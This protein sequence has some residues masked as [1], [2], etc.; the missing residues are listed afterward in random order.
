MADPRQSSEF[1]PKRFTAIAGTNER[2]YLDARQPGVTS[3]HDARQTLNENVRRIDRPAPEAK[4]PK[5]IFAAAP[6]PLPGNP[7]PPA[8]AVIDRWHKYSDFRI[9]V[10][11]QHQATSD[12][13][14]ESDAFHTI[15]DGIAWSKTYHAALALIYTNPIITIEVRG[16]F[17]EQI[18]IDVPYLHFQGIGMPFITFTGGDDPSETVIEVTSGCT[19]LK[20]EGFEIYN[21]NIGDAAILGLQIDEGV[22]SYSDHSDIWFKDCYLH[23]S[24]TQAYI[25][26][27]SY[28]E[29]CRFKSE[30]NLTNQSWAGASVVCR[31][32]TG[33]TTPQ[34]KWTCFSRCTL[35]GETGL[36]PIKKGEAFAI[37]AMF[38]DLTTW[39]TNIYT[40]GTNAGYSGTEPS[41]SLTGVRFEWCRII[42]WAENFGWALE[43]FQSKII[44]GKYINNTGAGNIHLLSHVFTHNEGTHPGDPDVNTFNW[45]D[46]CTARVNYLVNYDDQG[47]VGGGGVAVSNIWL[48][49]L[50]HSA[51]LGPFPGGSV[52]FNIG[53]VAGPPGAVPN[54]HPQ[55]S[56]SSKAFWLN[57]A[58]IPAVMS[59]LNVPYVF[60][61]EGDMEI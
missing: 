50:K 60:N 59:I 6:G 52:V 54:V 11:N 32:A 3:E 18:V 41:R 22:Q 1:N 58:V 51:P 34:S 21:P 7:F 24:S 37:K 14:I 28:F 17:D 39:V 13:Q 5:T 38:S 46:H 45:F 9:T 12:P 57:A 27:C 56:G 36:D 33:M 15:T 48:S 42:G 30:D 29:G 20:F 49:F 8:A 35:S 47:F 55:F 26:R 31:V 61:E 10:S 23:G 4:I 53:G 44:G 43:Y 25:Q 16:Y 40:I 19:K 2:R